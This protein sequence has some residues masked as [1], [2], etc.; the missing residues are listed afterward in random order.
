MLNKKEAQTKFL[1]ISKDIE[2]ELDELLSNRKG[3]IEKELDDQFQLMKQEAERK[4]A[5]DTAEIDEEKKG[6]MEYALF[7]AQLEDEG[8]ELR[9]TIDNHLKKVSKYR[10]EIW[11]MLESMGKEFKSVRELEN[12]YEKIQNDAYQRA[13]ILKKHLEEIYAIKSVVPE[14]HVFSE[15]LKIDL[16]YETNKLQKARVLMGPLDISE[17]EEDA[18]GL[19][20]PA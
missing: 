4:I 13:N 2:T 7:M 14:K 17:A 20:Q 16:A 3:A 8:N 6:L 5:K 11:E 1:S 18:G 15:K 12:N 19:V 9:Y 10:K